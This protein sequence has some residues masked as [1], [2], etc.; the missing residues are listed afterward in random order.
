[1]LIFQLLEVC[2]ILVLL[3]HVLASSSLQQA[4]RVWLG[5]VI[6][7]GTVE[8]LVGKYVAERLLC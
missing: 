8:T 5:V 4:T 7:R 2:D 3:R 1:M 6:E